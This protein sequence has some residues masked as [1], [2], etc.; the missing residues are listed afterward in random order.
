MKATHLTRKLRAAG[1]NINPRGNLFKREGSYIRDI[2][3]KI[4]ITVDVDDAETRSDH[5]T[6]IAN[7]LDELGI[8]Y[9]KKTGNRGFWIDS[10]I[11][12]L[13]S[14]FI[15]EH[16]NCLECIE[17]GKKARAFAQQYGANEGEYSIGNHK[18]VWTA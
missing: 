11:S 12:L 16:P 17:A 5:L 9:E 8:P 6:K 18:G 4:S 10:N 13:D 1:V 3:D 7:A 2:G 14:N 15:Y